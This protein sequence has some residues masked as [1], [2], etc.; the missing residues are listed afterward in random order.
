MS[1]PV[2]KQGD[3]VVGIDTHV[4]MIPLPGGAVPT[5]MSF[6]FNGPLVDGLSPT[7]WI[8][9][10]SVAVVGSGASNAP[11]HIPLAGAFQRPPSNHATVSSGSA[12]VFVDNQPIARANDRA[13]CCND[14][15]DQET[16]HVIAGGSV[17]A[18]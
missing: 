13:R 17:F 18:G 5:P 16:G 11:A 14:P 9:G 10:E 4:V 7:T 1:K 2:A 12:T 15:A 8:D 3:R 6:A